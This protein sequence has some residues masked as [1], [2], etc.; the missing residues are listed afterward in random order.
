MRLLP[1]TG[2]STSLRVHMQALG[3][4][5]VGDEYAQG[6]AYENFARLGLHAAEL[7]FLS[8]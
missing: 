1:I 8:S 6:E 7:S 3:Y 2:R 5:I 4:P